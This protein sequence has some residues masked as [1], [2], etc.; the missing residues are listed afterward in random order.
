M[1]EKGLPAIAFNRIAC[2]DCDLLQK[3]PTLAV[4]E[5]AYC[6]RCDA[7]LFTNQKNSVDR[8]LAFAITGL[9]FYV[10]ANMFPFLSLKALGFLQ[11]G[12]LLSTS[13][14][15]FNAGMPLLSLLLLLTTVI[16]PLTTLLGTIYILIQVKRDKFNNYTAPVF[17]FLRSTDTWGMLEIFMLAVIVSLVK[18]GD[19]A[20]VVFGISLYAF[21]LLILS[22]TLMSY[23]LNPEDVWTRLRNK[24]AEQ[25]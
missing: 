2:H 25:E 6:V 9:L 20:D 11:E 18:L 8:S 19:Y 16:F 3:T 23:S 24:M 22:L 14:S 13:F 21:V 17:R 15:L 4:G 12:T 10:I 5:V 1:K 7:V